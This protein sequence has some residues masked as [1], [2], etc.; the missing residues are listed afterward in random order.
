[1]HRF[2]T[3][4]LTTLLLGFGGFITAANASAPTPDA[5]KTLIATT[6]EAVRDALAADPALSRGERPGEVV[7]I[8]EDL[9]LPHIDTQMSGRLI[10]GRHWREASPT[11]RER[12][13]TGYKD[14]LL[15]TYATHATDY[16]AAEVA[17]LSA[18]PAGREGRALQV[19]TRVT[20]PGKPVATVDYRMIARNG[21]WKVFDAVVQGVS[22]VSTLRTAVAEEIQRIGI[23]GLNAKLQA[24][25]SDPSLLPPPRPTAN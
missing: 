5:G 18:A 22:L 14:L 6:I 4:L 12:F 20:R 11:Q 1:M 13:I 25:A 19:R 3:L 24:A 15:R 17:I 8:V 2:S 21:E 7:A 16:L 10:L 23:D 9:V